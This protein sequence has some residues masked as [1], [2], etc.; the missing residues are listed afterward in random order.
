MTL[1]NIFNAGTF[2]LMDVLEIHV[3]D[4]IACVPWMLFVEYAAKRNMHT[5]AQ[6]LHMFCKSL[7]L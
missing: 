3:Y 2:Y 1:L 4:Q 7:L 6:D 5:V